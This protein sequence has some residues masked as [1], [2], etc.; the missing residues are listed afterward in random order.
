MKEIPKEIVCDA[1]EEFRTLYPIATGPE[2]LWNKD[3]FLNR[4]IRGLMHI[5]PI[6][7]YQERERAMYAACDLLYVRDIED[8]FPSILRKVYHMREF[9]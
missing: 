6:E 4:A 9:W 8:V 2:R 3:D 5:S 7:G 1:A